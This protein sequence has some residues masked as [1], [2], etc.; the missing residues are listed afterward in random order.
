[1]Q[2]ISEVYASSYVDFDDEKDISH[3][4]DPVFVALNKKVRSHINAEKSSGKFDIEFRLQ[5]IAHT[6]DEE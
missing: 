6:R 2:I 3:L 5:V 1:M 4:L